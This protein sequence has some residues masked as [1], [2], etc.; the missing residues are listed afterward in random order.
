MRNADP[1]GGVNLGLIITPMLDMAFQLLSFFIMT[2]HPS[3]LEGHID[4]N[5]LPQVVRPGPVRPNLEDPEPEW[6]PEKGDVTTIIVRAVAKGQKEGTRQEGDPSQILIRRVEDPI[7]APIADTNDTWEA[8][9]KK[10]ALALRNHGKGETALKIEGDGNLKHQYVIQVY[11]IC[12]SAGY[13]D[14]AFV[15][16]KKTP[17]PR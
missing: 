17:G 2:Y 16:P 9:M 12:K 7:P 11:D 3:A 4:G 8:G 13:R 6:V 10:L 5:L 14:I 15:Y 1:G